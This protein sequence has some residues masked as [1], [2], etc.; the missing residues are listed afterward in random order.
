[1]ALVKYDELPDGPD[2]TAIEKLTTG[3]TDKKKYFVDKLSIAVSQVAAAFYPKDVIVR[4]S[5]F[6]TNEY[7]ALTGGKYF[8]PEEE[9]PMLGFRGASRY[10]NDRYRE[11]FRLECEAMKIV[12]EKMGLDNVKLMIPFCRTVDEGKKVVAL[13]EEFGLKRGDNGL[14]IYVMCEIPSNVILAEEFA[15]V[16]DGFSIGSNDLT[17]LTLGIDRDSTIISSLFDERNTA[18]KWMIATAIRKAKKAKAKIGLCGQ[19]P[20]DYSEFA[21]FLVEQGIDSISFN[22]DALIK[23]IEN[24][25]R[26][27]QN[28]LHPAIF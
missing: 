15:K 3:Y 27:E 4:M 23:G 18:A 13:M 19:A 1:M 8:E 5:D 11:G 24:I 20:S 28:I 21:Q 16:F 2:K 25:H 14:E 26:A 12:R 9:N 7:A 17:Q 10:Y 6:K 22:P